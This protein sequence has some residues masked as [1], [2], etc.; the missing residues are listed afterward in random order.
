MEIVNSVIGISIS[1]VEVTISV[2][3][4]VWFVISVNRFVTSIVENEVSEMLEQFLLSI[5][6][7]PLIHFS[8]K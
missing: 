3:G 7:N 5:I 6:V 8:Q 4:F 2:V 1:V